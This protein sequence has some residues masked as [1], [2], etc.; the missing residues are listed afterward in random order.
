MQTHSSNLQLE[1]HNG[2]QSPL[3]SF[4]DDVGIGEPAVI[5]ENKQSACCSEHKSDHKGQHE[6]KMYSRPTNKLAN[7]QTTSA[8]V[9]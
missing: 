3:W 9:Q 7:K 5:E 6:H 4:V 2:Y 8:I 1:E